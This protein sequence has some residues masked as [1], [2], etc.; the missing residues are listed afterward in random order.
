VIIDG[1]RLKIHEFNGVTN[2]KITIHPPPKTTEGNNFH[3]II[4][5]IN[6]LK[7]LEQNL[8]P[9][10]LNNLKKDPLLDISVE[11]RNHSEDR[12]KL[13]FFVKYF[14]FFQMAIVLMLIKRKNQEKNEINWI[15][16]E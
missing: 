7:T 5:K 11:Y 2:N 13:F 4:K 10:D 9:L 15:R 3:L 8:N 1:R 16:I 12:N 6:V 14:F